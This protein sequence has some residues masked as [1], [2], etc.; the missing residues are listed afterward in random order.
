MIDNAELRDKLAEMRGYKRQGKWWIPPGCESKPFA[1]KLVHPFPDGD[2]TTLAAV[3]PEGWDLHLDATKDRKLLVWANDECD[4][5]QCECFGDT[6][7]DARLRLTVAV[8]EAMSSN[9][10]QRKE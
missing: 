6:E 1:H 4:E 3:W 8:Y 5:H 7:Y 10:P 9:S 2:L